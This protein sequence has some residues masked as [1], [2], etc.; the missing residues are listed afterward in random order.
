MVDSYYAKY[1]LFVLV[2]V[3]LF[4][5]IDRQILSILAE[6]IKAD[7][8]LSDSDIGFLYGTAFAVFY[9]IFGIPLAR[10][11]D[12]WKRNKLISMGLGFWSLMT[13]LSGTAKGFAS[14]ALCRF[15]VGVG[16]ASATPAAYSF[17]YDYFS[18]RF[19]TT[20]LAVYNGGVYLG[21]GIGLFLGG[22]IL[23]SWNQA[24]PVSSAAPLGLKG[25]QI[26]FMAVG[27]PGLL[28]A[29]WVASLKEPQRGLADGLVAQ[30]D[31]QTESPWLVLKNEL[32]PMVPVINLWVLRR[33][34]AGAKAQWLNAGVGST[35][36]LAVVGLI[37]ATD[38]TLQWSALGVGIYCAFSWLQSLIC[39]DPVCFGLIFRCKSLCY[40][41]LYVGFNVFTAVA[42][43]F[44]SIP[45]YQR[46]HHVA[47]ADIGAVMGLYIAVAGLVGVI[48]GGVLADWLRRYTRR[49]KLYI[50]LGAWLLSLVAAI[51]L[52][53][54]NNLSMA[55]LGSFIFFF[56][57]PLTSAPAVSTMSDLAIPRTRAVVTAMNIMITT[58]LGA[59]LGPYVIGLLS[60]GLV[61]SG[62]DSGEALRQSLLMGLTP[63]V[64]GVVF[65]LLAI[66]HIVAD[67]DSRL[68]RAR[69]L[70]EDI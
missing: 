18:P 29:I 69:A 32:L 70:G 21:A 49:A 58:F 39:R 26:A 43:I 66:K 3:S 2:L 50:C 55:Y 40:L 14:L 67:E 27:L 34:G 16:E 47:A 54:A 51:F 65:L 12:S 19:R 63:H 37:Y 30:T 64:V 17:L 23:D 44:W 60:D 36:A 15:G 62:M 11:A 1:A 33:L 59:A 61:A 8:G 4:N 5:F 38:Q 7:L 13:A 68:D 52:L 22:A 46:Y 25:W 31:A 10:L 9:A 28:L 45:Y 6:D 56:A 57:G 24:Y 48:L 42:I 35:I 20:V 53:T 41:Y